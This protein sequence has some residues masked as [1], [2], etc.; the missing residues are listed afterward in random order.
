MK[1]DKVDMSYTKEKKERIFTYILEKISIDEEKLI[2]K[3][4]KTFETSDTTVRRYL[5]ELVANDVIDVN[6]NKKCGYEMKIYKFQKIYKN[7]DLEE[8]FIYRKDFYPQ[9]SDLPENV[10]HIWA[11]AF[12]EILN[13]AIEHSQSDTIFIRLEKTQLA[14]TVMIL[15]KGIGIF[16]NIVNF[17]QNKYQRK[18]IG[19]EDAIIELFKGKL[20]T[21]EKYHSGEGIFFTSRMMDRFFI[22]S[23][24]TVFSHDNMSEHIWKEFI[25]KDVLESE[26]VPGVDC[27]TMVYLQISNHSQKNIKEV[28]DMFAPVESGFVKTSI[29]IKHVCCEFGYPVSRSQARRLCARFDEFEEV[30]LDFKEV[31]NIGQAFAHEI[32]NVFQKSHPE[33]KLIVENAVPY[34][35]GMIERVK[36]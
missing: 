5:N 33:L 2:S 6:L 29:P 3:V 28:F 30:I 8:D 11:Y 13:N 23:S 25:S 21:A 32:F 31:D 17:M 15:D 20:T 9:L 18:D 26:T 7:K 34:V 27:G 36:R 1:G 22:L 24:N 19:I 14:T 16:N 10:Q 35:A 4:V 12:T